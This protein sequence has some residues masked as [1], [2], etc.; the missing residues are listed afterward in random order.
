ME[1]V[2]INKE[3]KGKK[4]QTWKDD[5]VLTFAVQ[6]KGPNP[7]PQNPFKCKVTMQQPLVNP[8][9]KGEMGLESLS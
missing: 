4:N 8:A 1:E 5:L 9:L 2:A 7:D 3:F 6:T